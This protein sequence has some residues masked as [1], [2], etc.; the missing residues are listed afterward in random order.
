MSQRLGAIK[1]HRFSYHPK[2][3]PSWPYTVHP[4]SLLPAMVRHLDG[5]MIGGGHLIRF[6]K[7]IAANYFPPS[8]RI[9]HP[10]GYWLTP[11]LL[12][13]DHGCPI[14]WNAPGV[15]GEVPNWAEAL[16]QLA[17]GLS[18]YI[19]VRDEPSRV[20]LQR[21]VPESEIVLVPDTCF[22]IAQLLGEKPSPRLAALRETLKLTRPYI[23]VQATPG[24]DAFVRLVRRHPS[25]FR[26]YQLVALPIGPALGDNNSI[27]IEQL[28][29]ITWLPDW[30]HPLLVAE[31]IKRSSGV[32]GTSMHPSITALAF[33]V[34]V[35][36][37]AAVLS[38]IVRTKHEIL[39]TFPGTSL[40][41]DE[42]DPVW[43]AERLRCR[44]DGRAFAKA[45]SR[46]PSHW[47]RIASIFADGKD[48]PKERLG[49]FGQSL[50][51][52]LETEALRSSE[53]IRAT[54]LE[55]EAALVRIAEQEAEIAERDRQA[56]ELA[57]SVAAERQAYAAAITERDRR[58]VELADSADVDRQ[59]FVASIVAHERRIMQLNVD[60]AARERVIVVFHSTSYRIT[61]PVR[62]I[63]HRLPWW[64]SR[65][66]SRSMIN[67]T[68]IDREELATAP[69][70]WA[71]TNELFS[72]RGRKA[73]VAGYPSDNFKTVKGHDSDREWEYEAR[74]LIDLG[75][76]EI[77]APEGLS[78]AWRQMATDLLSPAYRAAM[79][80]LTG[81]DLMTAPME[82]YVC[83]FGPGA[84]QGAHRDLPEKIVTHVFYF[85]DEW[86]MA[87]GGCFEHPRLA[88]ESY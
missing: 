9:H 4:L 76:N 6:D 88:N 49:S 48:A 47:D 68:R 56:A 45:A 60:A 11:A 62:W 24:L 10:T 58:A 32:V 29:D 82:A 50:P 40:F 61:A 15:Y 33:G 55:I 42:I 22:G 38:S 37:P 14:V 34:P 18:R 85:N 26:D 28:P 66:R 71:F 23:V 74:A 35:F 63:G 2:T 41:G 20:V 13:L 69:F 43:F 3:P 46:L 73:L 83:H 12:A 54:S 80:R 64:K 86:N 59:V 25:V 78:K 87:N 7:S 70:E 81:R 30:P 53:A 77:S 31:L 84:L 16:I 79:T 21:V 39:S 75:G 72:P 8:A 36:K 5:L 51:G 1:F 27:L 65:K 57:D 44:N 67:L 17:M 19:A 52:L